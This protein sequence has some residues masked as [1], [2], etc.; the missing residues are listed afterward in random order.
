M[1]FCPFREKISVSSEEQLMRN[2]EKSIC[3][4]MAL[5]LLDN[6]GVIRSLSLQEKAGK[7]N[8]VEGGDKC[9]KKC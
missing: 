2:V 9:S 1:A 6:S 4:A 3:F 5:L 7:V 8:N